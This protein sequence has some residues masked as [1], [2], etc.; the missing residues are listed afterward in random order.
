MLATCVAAGWDRET[1]RHPDHPLQRAIR[2]T[3]AELTGDGD[4]AHVTVVVG[5]REPRAS[6][7]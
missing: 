6:P 2:A 4:P 1:Y 5:D 3:V 7:P